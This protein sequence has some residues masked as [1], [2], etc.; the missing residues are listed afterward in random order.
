MKQEV[1]AKDKLITNIDGNQPYLLI[2][3]NILNS[4]EDVY[5]LDGHFCLLNPDGAVRR[6]EVETFIGLN[7]QAIVLLVENPAIIVE[8]R[9]ARDGIDYDVSDIKEFQQEEIVYAKEI[10][11]IINAPLFILDGAND[12]ENALHFIGQ[13][14]KHN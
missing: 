12:L 11:E 13:Y 9:K 10:A 6:I 5:L 1:F 7:P 3:V 4:N 2:A 14:I 8:R